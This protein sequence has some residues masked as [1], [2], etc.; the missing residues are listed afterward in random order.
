MNP[1]EL[2][3]QEV[4]MLRS[5][6]MPYMEVKTNNSISKQLSIIKLVIIQRDFA[7]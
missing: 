3:K 7:T 5:A 4:M 1:K 6:S 2:K